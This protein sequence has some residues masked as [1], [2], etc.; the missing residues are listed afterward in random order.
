M[1]EMRDNL[2]K[3]ARD[4][5]KTVFNCI[6]S[7]SGGHIA[8]S[9]SIIEILVVLYHRILRIDPD[10]PKAPDR[11]RFILSKGHA[12]VSLYAILADQGFFP[13]KELCNFGK[14]GSILGGHPDM[15]KVPG[16]EASTGSLGHGF[17]FGA[18][19][20][21]AGKLDH[22]DYRVFV[23]LGDGECQE[24]SV[25][26]TA[27]FASHHKLDNLI[28]IIDYNKIQAMDR[29][30]RIVS[31]EPLTAKWKAF[32]WE[33]K[34]ADGHNT[35]ELNDILSCVPFAKGKP[36]LLIAHTIKGKGI[37]FMENTAIWHYRMPNVE[38]LKAACKE[39]DLEKEQDEL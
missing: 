26:E 29:L 33:V 32:G 17:S 38:E 21:L 2:E 28:A 3:E 14:K 35:R 10:N 25:W 19:M 16:V 5:R 23:L 9:L 20:A 7:S 30:D 27:M 4:L 12:G 15:H 31:L 34:E 24:G 13:K 8:S 36:S 1:R 22:K 11:D 37:A 6:C 39:L 18:G